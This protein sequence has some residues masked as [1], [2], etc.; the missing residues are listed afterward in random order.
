[1]GPLDAPPRTDALTQKRWHPS[2]RSVNWLWTVTKSWCQ[3]YG[4]LTADRPSMRPGV[5]G[6]HDHDNLSALA[7]EAM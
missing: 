7:A 1:M 2:K 6:L 4:G 3:F 5:V